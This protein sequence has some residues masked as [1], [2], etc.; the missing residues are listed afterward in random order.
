LEKQKDEQKRADDEVRMRDAVA[1]L[2]PGSGQSARDCQECPEMV[3]VPAGSFTMGS[4]ST[5]RGRKPNEGPQRPVTIA[6]SLAV[7]KFE[8]TFGE[9][10]ACVRGGGCASNR[11]PDDAGFNDNRRPVMNV[12][13]HD[14]RE[15]VSWISQTTGKKY[16][17]PSEAEWE[18]FARAGSTTIYSFGSDESRLCEF[19]NVG[20][21][22]L[23]K[24]W[25][26]G[27]PIACNDGFP[28]AAPVG[29]F[30][31]N[32]FGL[33][34]VHGNL[35]EIVED[36]YHPNYNGA[37][38]DGSVWRGGQPNTCVVRGGSYLGLGD[39]VRSAIRRHMKAD[40][41]TA[42]VGFRVVREF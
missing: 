18:Y 3:M 13:C 12:S 21:Q 37:P 40:N 38:G 24:A 19:G 29:S 34:D 35:L 28:W 2:A 36:P 17:L 20:D 41:R 32:S 26:G 5:E 8:V 1:T 23:K 4:P 39:A 27:Q 7:G 15:Y 22:A 33:F 30:K 9:W 10:R 16:R 6:R 31:P 42:G 14:A 25:P 11:H